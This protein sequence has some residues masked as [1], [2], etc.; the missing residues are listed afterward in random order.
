MRIHSI[1]KFLGLPIVILTLVILY[2]SW[3]SNSQLSAYLLVPALFTVVIYVFHGPLDHW[4]LTRFPLP[5]D[6]KLK[7]WLEKYFVFYQKLDQH[8]KREFEYRTGLYLD[9]RMFKSVGSE[10]RDVPEDI[11]L[12][13]AA[14]GVY[15]CLKLDDYLIGDMDRIFLYKH[16]F[17]TPINHRLH[18][19][20]TNLE[21]GVIILSLEQ[22]TN[23][24]LNPEDYYN[25]AFHAY[26]EAFA[27]MNGQLSFPDCS[28]TW[29]QIESISGWTKEI[30]MNQTGLDNIS[31]LPVHIT[32][33]FSKSS[34]YKNRMPEH[35]EKFCAIFNQIP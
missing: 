32:L 7:E 15:M 19:V 23:A 6:P 16:P 21:D 33:F 5:F 22:L 14:H 35:Y 10:W 31:L 25:V 13:V 3:S 11:K 1:S 24:V 17:P 27:G 34:Q 8:L 2:Q 30:I 9:A 4:W 18:S 29:P 20:E 26:A 28:M 12:M